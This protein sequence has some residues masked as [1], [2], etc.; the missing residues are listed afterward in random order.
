MRYAY[1]DTSPALGHMVEIVEDKPAIRAFFSAVR[2]SAEKWDGVLAIMSHVT[3][4]QVQR[5]VLKEKTSREKA[6]EQAVQWIAP[7]TTS[8]AAV[9]GALN[10]GARF[11]GHGCMVFEVGAQER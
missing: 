9:V 1:V 2:K 7:V 11:T 4:V 10:G 6:M 3:P 8:I 5:S